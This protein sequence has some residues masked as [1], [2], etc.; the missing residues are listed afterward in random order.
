MV[1]PSAREDA[2]GGGRGVC[3]GAGKSGGPQGGLPAPVADPAA[4]ALKADGEKA[5]EDDFDGVI[6]GG[7]FVQ[8]QDTGRV[9]LIQRLPDKHDDDSAY[10]R[11][12]APG[13]CLDVDDPGVW[14]GALREWEEETGATLGEDAEH[15]GSFLSPD[16]CYQAFVVR[17]P[18]EAELDLSPQADEVADIGWWDP[19]DLGDDRVRDKVQELLP[20]LDRFLAPAA[21]SK[22]TAGGFHRHTDRITAHYAHQI[23][24]AIAAI[25]P[26][27]LIDAA[28]RHAR[29]ETVDA[30]K[31]AADPFAVQKRAGDAGA[32]ATP[33]EPEPL[34]KRSP[35]PPQLVQRAISILNNGL[36]TAG[37]LKAVLGDLWGDAGLQG[38]NGA[39]E[40]ANGVMLAS[41]QGV[42][43]ELPDDYWSDWRPGWGQAAARAADGGLARLLDEADV[44]IRGITG[45]TLDRLGNVI[46]EG[47]QAGD[48]V[49]KIGRAA[50]AIVADP[51][52]AWLIA[53]T[54]A[55]RAMTATSMDTYRANGVPQLDWL[56]QDDACDLCQENADAAPLPVDGDWPNGPPPVHPRCRCA[57]APNLDRGE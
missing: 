10:A 15:A 12:E 38:A 7:L 47:V 25:F 36:S 8:A 54:E 32:Y 43:R 50:R 52:R 42:V 35:I 24:R 4:V 3:G 1:A 13:G 16:G 51:Q 9:L 40:A 29:G 48:S 31:P 39:A 30:Y 28:I 46:A 44:T 53:D 17:V 26:R 22:A 34:V 33:G 2:R 49:D 19:A 11:W 55:A 37:K 23:A 57:L 20:S 21:V 27:D 41:L 14:D 56:L 45:T 6:A 18:C 5:D